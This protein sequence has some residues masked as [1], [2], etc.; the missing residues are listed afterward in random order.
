MTLHL[1]GSFF[2]KPTIPG[3]ESGVMR[4][5]DP[6]YTPNAWCAGTFPCLSGKWKAEIETSDEGGWGTRV[7]SLVV[8]HVSTDEFV[9]PSEKSEIDVGVDSGQCG[10]YDESAYGTIHPVDHDNQSGRYMEMCD[11]TSTPEQAAVFDSGVVSSSGF[12]DGSYDLYLHRNDE[13][14][15]VAAK[16]VFIGNDYEEDEEYLE[17]EDEIEEDEEYHPEDT[18]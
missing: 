6:C 11:L 15:V 4:V 18:A 17:E 1:D 9:D 3:S 14:L 5:S 2:I 13:G 7:S 16:I 8:R 10:F 12:G